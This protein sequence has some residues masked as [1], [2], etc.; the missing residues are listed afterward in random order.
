MTTELLS[1]IK[2]VWY[3]QMTFRSLYIKRCMCNQF[4][5]N[6]LITIIGVGKN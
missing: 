1:E 2:N 4:D 3:L 5:V 6:E